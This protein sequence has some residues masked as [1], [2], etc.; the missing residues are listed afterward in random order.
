MTQRLQKTAEDFMQVLHTCQCLD[1]LPRSTHW[2]A[3]VCNRLFLLL[4][5]GKEGKPS[6]TLLTSLA[7][8]TFDLFLNL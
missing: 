5:Q 7:K 6:P 1:A 2:T 3:S 8:E 4:H